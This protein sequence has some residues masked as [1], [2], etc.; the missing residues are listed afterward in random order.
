M[1]D[2]VCNQLNKAKRLLTEAIAIWDAQDKA[3]IA[4]EFSASELERIIESAK[5]VQKLG[6][7]IMLTAN[8][9]EANAR[10]KIAARQTKRRLRSIKKELTKPAPKPP[11]SQL[12]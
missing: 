7:N 9:R 6:V 5:A 10:F 1:R 8:H 3:G 11:I 12:E 4:P 2:I